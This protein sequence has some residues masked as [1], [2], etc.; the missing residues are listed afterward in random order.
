MVRNER[1]IRQKGLMERWKRQI[2]N[3]MM[4]QV[5]DIVGIK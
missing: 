5:I 4:D 3:G 1:C 2:A